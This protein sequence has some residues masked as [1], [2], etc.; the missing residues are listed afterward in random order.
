MSKNLRTGNY[1]QTQLVWYASFKD[2]DH[3]HVSDARRA[4]FRAVCIKSQ[5]LY[6][7]K[8]QRFN[9]KKIRFIIFKP[10]SLHSI[11]K[12]THDKIYSTLQSGPKKKALLN[13][14]GVISI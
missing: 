14:N 7:Q 5:N 9:Y 6:T 11:K 3:L 8:I 4:T 10:Y 13:I 1:I 12:I 2:T